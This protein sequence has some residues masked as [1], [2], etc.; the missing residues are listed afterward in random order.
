MGMV[1]SEMRRAARQ[2]RPRV[3]VLNGALRARVLVAAAPVD[4][5]GAE[6][7]LDLNPVEADVGALPLR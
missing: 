4:R 2:A 5:L 6:A 1:L 7:A 3:E